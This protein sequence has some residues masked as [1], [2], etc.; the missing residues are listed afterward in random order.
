MNVSMYTPTSVQAIISMIWVSPDLLQRTE[1]YTCDLYGGRSITDVNEM[2]YPF[3]CGKK[4]KVE[5]Y[6]LPPF[7]HCLQK[8]IVRAKYQAYIWWKC[9]E[10][11]P[12]IPEPQGHDWKL[13]ERKLVVDWMSNPSAPDAVMEFLSCICTPASVNP[14]CVC[15]V[16]ALRCTDVYCLSACENMVRNKEED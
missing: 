10:A 6:R 13:D 7:R 3:F 4:V 11:N 15:I 12:K 9:L 2:R 5:S 16:N 14:I 8:Q 1:Q